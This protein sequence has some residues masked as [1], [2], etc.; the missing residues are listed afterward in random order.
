MS[1]KAIRI[2]I[3]A[4]FFI[5][6]AAAIIFVINNMSSGNPTIDLP[7]ADLVSDNE[8]DHI[9]T[10]TFPEGLTVTQISEKLE[11]NGV[12]PKADFLNAVQNPSDELLSELGITNKQERIFTLEGYVFP[13]TYEFYKNEN[14][15]SVLTRFVDNFKSKITETDK[16]RAEALGYTIDEIITIASI[17][18]EESGREA[19]DAK[20][21]SVLH[22]RL[23]SGVKIEC[24]V[25]ITYLTDNCEPYLENG[26]TEEN[27]SNYNTYKCPAL[28]KGP[29]TNPGYNS[30]QAA[31]YPA[32]TDFLFFVT[33]K[34]W[35][36]LYAA[37]W[38][39]HVV[40]C[41]NAGIE[42]Y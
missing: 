10:V 16:A 13:D 29:I 11:E 41:R 18:Q 24:D 15:E 36:Y 26:L 39:E 19:E 33:D 2:I 23:N 21:S 40:N 35:N 9:V 37:T 7:G 6:A 3:T 30:I 1:K 27:K 22:N 8:S 4:V 25:T 12:C 38:D 28:P 20:V 14:A 34:D 42:G 17:I 32:E 5:V 31:L